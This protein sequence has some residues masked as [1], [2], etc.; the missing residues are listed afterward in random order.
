M[1]ITLST[2]VMMAVFV[3]AIALGF[4]RYNA[5]ANYVENN[6]NSAVIQGYSLINATS[7]CAINVSFQQGDKQLTACGG[8]LTDRVFIKS[9]AQ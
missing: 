7:D 6:Y 8:V 3:A 9:S 2:T 4:Y 5:L 1:K